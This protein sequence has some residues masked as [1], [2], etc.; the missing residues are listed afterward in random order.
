MR[1]PG[2]VLRVS[3][4]IAFELYRRNG[5]DR[6]GRRLRSG[7]H[8]DAGT[9]Q[10]RFLTV[11]AATALH[12]QLA[13]I[14]PRQ[15][16]ATAGLVSVPARRILLINN[17]DIGSGA[18][19]IGWS[20]LNGYLD[21][22]HDAWYAV[23]VKQSGSRYVLPVR[24][25][26]WANPWRRTFHQLGDA[27]IPLI[28]TV[29]GARWA[30]EQ[31]RR[32]GSPSRLLD[33]WQGR[34]EIAFPVTR[35]FLA[36]LSPHPDIVHCH[37]MLGGY[38]DLRALPG[39]SWQAP[40][41]LTLHNAWLLSGHC[42]QPGVC[43]RWRTGCG[44][45]PDLRLY[46]SL[47][48]DGT[49]GNWAR[50]S[51][52]L[53]ASR[54]YV[55]T[56]SRWLMDMVDAS[57]VRPGTVQT[58]VIPHGVDLRTFQPGDM[59]TA[60]RQLDIPAD[61]RVMLLVAAG[62]FQNLWKDPHTLQDALALAARNLPGERLL[63]LVVGG[64]GDAREEGVDT[65]FV[66]FQDSPDRMAA[67][68]RSADVVVHVT[69]ADTF[70]TVVLEALACG[71]PVIATNVGGIPEQVRTLSHADSAPHGQS[72]P[73]EKATGVLVPPRDPRA[74][75]HWIERLLRDDPLR[76]QLGR[77]AR[78]DAVRRFDVQRQVDDY[79]AWYEEILANRD[80]TPSKELH[81]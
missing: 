68:Y 65:R 63:L 75:A 77:N 49:A 78:A 50:K 34:E 72:W 45:C 59:A 73:A 69:K 62:G 74:L 41:V 47:R 36:S 33:W 12:W 71:K 61:A 19:R 20:L 39:L 57:L 17:S 40:T 13:G 23:D 80:R 67:F 9:G 5:G 79:L 38:F 64:G 31:L 29:R 24:E 21:R 37:D 32:L 58:R 43:D 54:V 16:A 53:A 1:T 10:T 60:R 70:P 27:F 44:Q 4:W 2:S 52:I 22:G 25:R 51:A 66:P 42:S 76:E 18:A 55:A 3:F 35:D 81:S 56:P 8:G 26:G 6:A 28:G 14:A 48:R 11:S 15:D 7:V 30:R 46:P